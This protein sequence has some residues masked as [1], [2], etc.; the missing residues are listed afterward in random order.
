MKNYIIAIWMVAVIT[1]SANL[2]QG[3]VVDVLLTVETAEA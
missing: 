3:Q 1:I 2:G